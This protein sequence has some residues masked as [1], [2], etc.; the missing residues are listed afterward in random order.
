MIFT[1]PFSV[2]LP[3]QDIL[4]FL[5]ESNRFQDSNPV[6][7]DAAH[8]EISI[9]KGKARELTQRIGWSL[10][11]RGIGRDDVVVHFVE[12]QVM[13]APTAFGILCAEAVCATCAPTATAFEVA[14][15]VNLSS[16]KILICSP[17]TRPVAEAALRQ[18]TL[19]QSPELLVMDSPKL[20]IRQANTG[21]SILTD[22]TLQWPCITDPAI[23]QTRTACLIY[24]SGTTGLPKGVRLSHANFIANI[25]QIMYHFD[26]R[27]HLIRS[28]NRFPAMA[29]VLPNSN[30]AGV[31]LHTMLP[32]R[33]GWQIYQIPKYDLPLMMS[34]SAH[35]NSQSSSSLLQSGSAL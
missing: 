35:T 26:P 15:Q 31:I 21:H 10:R 28:E 12:N 19:E 13:I 32:L 34:T 3:N 22:A 23:L 33:I 9:T 30:A 27:Y 16:P 8:P 24:S 18:C 5:F 2:D 17:Q 1:S 20:D 14:R 7:L 6:W 25:Q 29:G 4:T 11:D